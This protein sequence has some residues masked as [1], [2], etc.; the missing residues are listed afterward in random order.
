MTSPTLGRVGRVGGGRLDQLDRKDIR[1]VR[2]DA[3]RAPFRECYEEVARTRSLDSHLS[4]LPLQ[5][6]RLIARRVL[7]R[8]QAEERK[9]PFIAIIGKE[10]DDWFVLWCPVHE[11][12]QTLSSV[13]H[14]SI[15]LSWFGFIVCSAWAAIFPRF[16]LH[17]TPTGSSWMNLVEGFFRD[18]SQQ[19]I[20]PGSFS[21]VR[22][23]VDAIMEYLAQ[24]NL[25]PKRYVWKAKGE[26]ILTK[27]ERVWKVALGEDKDVTII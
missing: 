6:Q 8:Q 5:R 15:S 11:R 12:P 24:H 1:T 13:A 17:F 19:A 9:A 10:G 14:L 25:N 7:R 23:L 2:F 27:I 26:K 4:A 18:L 3:G 20:L 21:S 22:Q 16:E